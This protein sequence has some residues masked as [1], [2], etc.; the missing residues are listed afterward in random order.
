MADLASTGMQSLDCVIFTGNGRVTG[1]L[2]T[3]LGRVSDALN[4]PDA[5]FIILQGVKV[6]QL[7]SP[8][9]PESA[10][11]SV[12][13][14]RANVVVVSPTAETREAARPPEMPGERERRNIVLEA[15]PYTVAGT[16]HVPTGTDVVQYVTEA[17]QAFVAITNATI[18]YRPNPKLSFDA[19]FIMVNRKLIQSVTEAIASREV[20]EEDDLPPADLGREAGEV[21]LA[22]QV[23]NGADIAGLEEALTQLSATGGITRRSYEP[24][25]AVFNE[26]DRADSLYVVASGT[27]VVQVTDRTSGG[28]KRLAELKEGDVFGEVALLGEGLRTASVVNAQSGVLYE[29][30]ESAMKKLT[31]LAPSATTSLLRVMV[32]RRS[33]RG[34][35]LR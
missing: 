2:Q 29:I 15:G 14:Q 22:T 30:K 6:L 16:A 26:G 21:L 35:L 19:E 23:F 8:T 18:T 20:E 24:G 27:F 33:P 5:E 3:P 17:A 12:M 1:K 25:V 7:A 34:G 11:A 10:V 4:A 28:M 31:A 9:A 13:L 32:Q